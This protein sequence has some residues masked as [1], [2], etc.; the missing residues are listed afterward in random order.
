MSAMPASSAPEVNPATAYA[1]LWPISFRPRLRAA[2]RQRP[3]RPPEVR[4]AVPLF[5]AAEP[6][7]FERRD[8]ARA[9]PSRLAQVV[10]A[11]V[12]KA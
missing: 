7:A 8:E 2:R 6:C 4:I 12:K 5:D 9:R 3:Q 11:C 1:V 10:S